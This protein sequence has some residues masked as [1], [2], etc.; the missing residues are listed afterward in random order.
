MMAIR[1]A[2]VGIWSFD[3]QSKVFLFDSMMMKLNDLDGSA[4]EVPQETLRRIVHPDDL[5]A[6]DRGL[7][8]AIAGPGDFAMEYRIVWRDGSIHYIRALGKLERDEAGKAIG[9]IGTNWDITREKEALLRL[10]NE[11][12]ER[13]RVEEALRESEERFSVII[14]TSPDGMAISS[15]DGTVEYLTQHCAEMWGY[16]SPDELIG[17][18]ILEYVDPAYHEKAVYFLNEMMNG[19]MT[20]AAEYLMIKKDGT[21]FY[22]E[23]NANILRDRNGSPTGILYIE[24][25][26]TDRHRLE[27]E[28]KDM[29]VKDQLT[30]L[31]NRRK[32]DETLKETG[33][34]DA[35]HGAVSVIM[36]DIDWFKKVN[37][38]H[39]HLVGDSVLVTMSRIL[40][41]GIRKNDV[42]GRWGGEEFIIICPQTELAGAEILAEKLRLKV[43]GADFETVKQKTASFGVAQLKPGETM[44]ALLS[45]CDRALYKAKDK[46]RNRVVTELAV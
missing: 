29:A 11:I 35:G 30:G 13:R 24:R 2:E 46:G 17:H 37:D 25:D 8:A 38:E 41:S 23:A 16:D 5:A 27:A 45:R 39:G 42:L 28:M 21:R 36:A 43:E 44:D 22:S 33:A 10:E 6:T 7:E 18:N 19:H 31:F 1:A 3:I 15:L 9:I 20:G 26:V 12:A 4:G 32:I 14:E 40:E 34:P